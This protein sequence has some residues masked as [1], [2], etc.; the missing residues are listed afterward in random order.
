M[1]PITIPVL[2]IVLRLP[3]KF[4][5]AAVAGTAMLGFVHGAGIVFAVLGTIAVHVKMWRLL[6]PP[7]NGSS[8]D[9]Q[10]APR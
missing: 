6:K 2:W 1:M 9:E 5:E 8:T 4:I 3:F 10:H 7:A